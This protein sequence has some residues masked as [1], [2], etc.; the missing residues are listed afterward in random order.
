MHKLRYFFFWAL[1]LIAL[2]A[3]VAFYSNLGDDTDVWWHLRYG[4]YF[5]SRHTWRADHSIYSWTPADGSWAYVTWVGS[6]ILYGIYHLGGFSLLNILQWFIFL[7]VA[8]LAV[9]AVHRGGVSVRIPHVAAMFLTGAAV[10]PV[11]AYIKPE[12]F[13]LLFFAVTVFIYIDSKQSGRCGF[14]VYP[15]LFLLWVNTHG[16]F[17]HGLA[18]LAVMWLF[19]GIA[20]RLDYQSALP[21]RQWKILTAVLGLSGIAVC[22]NPYG[23]AYHVRIVEYILRGGSHVQSITAYAPLWNHLFPKQPVFRLFDA[24]WIMVFMGLLALFLLF[25]LY[26]K[27]RFFDLALSV[28]LTLFFV[29]GITMSRACIYFCVL[30]LFAMIYLSQL[31]NSSFNRICIAAGGIILIFASVIGYQ[32][33][34]LNTFDSWFGSGIDHIVPVKE[35]EIIKKYKLPPPIFNDYLTGGYLIWALY[36]EY[37]VFIDPRYGP[38]ATTGVWR[39]Y[40]DLTRNGSQASF[41]KFQRKYPFNTAIINVGQNHALTDLFFDAPDWSLVYF[42]RVAAVFVRKAWLGTRVLEGEM[43]AEKFG[44]V[45]NPQILFAAFYLYC[46]FDIAGARTIYSIYQTNV[47]PWYAERGYHLDRMRRILGSMPSG[48]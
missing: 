17:I 1:S 2:S 41:A 48:K 44:A 38:Y 34:V 19:E 25:R 29:L 14:W 12:L 40:L 26:W 3:L 21:M 37:K 10:N 24:A 45:N 46:N 31:Y 23:A 28:S 43:K 27:K 8:L 9:V 5:R 13:T 22:V 11:M 20:L 4:E 16:G 35:C 30:W 6:I 15:F 47:R 33:R 32:V 42:D 7:S 36:P 39:D 18:F